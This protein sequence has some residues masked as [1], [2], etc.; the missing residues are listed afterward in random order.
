MTS[1]DPPQL[2]GRSSF[3]KPETFTVVTKTPHFV[4]IARTGLGENRSNQ[5]K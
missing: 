2:V 5:G 1:I 4:M 3:P